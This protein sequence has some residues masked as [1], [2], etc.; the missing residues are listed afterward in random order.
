MSL[1]PSFLQQ[2]EIVSTHSL[3][4]C[5]S[6][7]ARGELAFESL[8]YTSMI[9]V[10]CESVAWNGASDEGIETRETTAGAVL[11]RSMKSEMFEAANTSSDFWATALTTMLFVLSI[12]IS[13]LA[14][15]VTSES[16]N[17]AEI[18]VRLEPF[19]NESG[20]ESSASL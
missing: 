10:A 17:G 13:R 11:L 9:P 6:G 19:L 15:I 16:K 20:T 7:W 2:E 3:R 8:T 5:A 18:Y 14:F 4:T 1:S 12:C